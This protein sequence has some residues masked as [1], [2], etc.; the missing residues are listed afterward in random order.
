MD[1]E[2]DGMTYDGIR[3]IDP[4]VCELY[5]IQ[6]QTG[7]GG[8]PVRY[9]YKYPHTVKYRLHSDKSKSW[10]KDRGLGMNHLFG[11]DFAAKPARADPL[12]CLE[13]ADSWPWTVILRRPSSSS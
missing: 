11:P 9:A 2:I 5:G 8:E 4:D 6:L 13:W 12:D 7:E 1:I 10:V 3:G